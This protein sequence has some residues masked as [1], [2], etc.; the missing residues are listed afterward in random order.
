MY[1]VI[2]LGSNSFH[3]LIAELR[4]EHFSVI[5]RCSEKI[6]LADNLDSS[7]Q[8]SDAAISRGLSCLAQFKS[9]LAQHPIGQIKV[10]GTE[11]IRR[12]DNARQF[13]DQAQQLGFTIEIISGEQEA[14]WIFDGICGPL[15]DSNNLRLTIDI[16]GASTE[17]A[18]GSYQR[19]NRKKGSYKKESDKKLLLAKSIALGCVSWRNIY[20]SP[21]L[22]YRH[23][24]QQAKQSAAKKLASVLDRLSKEH[25]DEVYASSGSAKMLSA[26]SHANN[27]SDGTITRQS[28]DAIENMLLE[29]SSVNEINI[30][31]LKPQR[32]DLLAPGLVI[33]S[34]I[35]NTLAIDEIFYSPTALREGILADMI[36]QRVDDQLSP[37]TLVS[38]L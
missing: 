32:V 18:L 10:V 31:G 8:L 30:P 17:I 33:M 35:M 23:N 22:D 29:F 15:P 3:L 2:D 13:I 37:E 5:D 14:C 9:V 4:D 26:I 27:W 12:A 34:T 24:H 38:N 21:S 6:Q 7:G 25:W 28:I 11:A 36:N 19:R 16:G 1:A 20:F